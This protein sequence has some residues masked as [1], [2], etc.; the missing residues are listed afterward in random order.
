MGKKKHIEDDVRAESEL[1]EV[2][3]FSEWV[4]K[5]DNTIGYKGEVIK[6]KKGEPFDAK[7]LPNFPEAAKIKFFENK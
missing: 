3:Q 6:I 2:E 5:S 1:V 7:R 4:A